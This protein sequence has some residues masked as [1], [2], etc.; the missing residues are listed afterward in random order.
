MTASFSISSGFDA[1]NIRVLS[2]DIS[3]DI[4]RAELEIRR[5]QD[6]DFYQWFHFR[7]SG[8]AGREVE[9]VT[10]GSPAAAAGFLPGDI[11]LSVDGY[12]VYSDLSTDRVLKELATPNVRNVEVD[13]YRDKSDKPLVV[14]GPVP[15]SLNELGLRL[16]PI[17]VEDILI[18]PFQH[19]W[20]AICTP[21]EIIHGLT[22][23][24]LKVKTVKKEV[25]GPIGMMRMIY[26]V[27]ENGVASWAFFL[28]VLNALIGGFNLFPFPALDG[29]RF[30]VLAIAGIRGKEID[31][32]REMV[33]HFAGIM[34]LLS[35]VGI[36]SIQDIQTWWAGT[37]LV[38]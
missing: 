11:L 35:L 38:K 37:P 22:A 7:V 32:S 18:T 15:S 9:A 26:Q 4:W 6:S 1:G 13:I 24:H 23:G 10:P 36:I 17:N 34:V 5:D 2:T 16:K 30:L 31:P 28:A 8:A 29:A 3:G 25:S 14:P 20:K 12:D 21:Y 19:I 27:S 33:F